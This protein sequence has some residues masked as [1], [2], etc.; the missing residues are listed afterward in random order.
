M[1]PASVTTALWSWNITEIERNRIMRYVPLRQGAPLTFADAMR[2]MTEDES[3]R[4]H[5]SQ[6]LASSTF[7][8]YRWET[9]PVTATSSS[10]RF[11]FVL[12]DDPGLDRPA[13]PQVFAE[14]FKRAAPGSSIVVFPSLGNDAHLIVPCP[15]G[16]ASTYVHLASFVR[17]APAAQVHE[18]WQRTGAETMKRLHSAP[19]WLSTA[20]MGVAWLHV[21]LDSRPK[22]YAYDAYRTDRD[23]PHAAEAASYARQHE[24]RYRK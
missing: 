5:L 9:P 17:H 16:P 19:T 12:V 7:T 20:G 8:G 4:S 23:G 24:R 6:L 1:E 18:L 13:A 14:H 15:L 22:Y 2:L 21:R 10:R 11:E 3:F